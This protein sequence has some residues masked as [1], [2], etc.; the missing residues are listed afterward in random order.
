MGTYTLPST[1]GTD[2]TFVTGA[3]PRSA[4]LDA[5]SVLESA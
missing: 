2:S 3:P 5:R 1:P 4:V